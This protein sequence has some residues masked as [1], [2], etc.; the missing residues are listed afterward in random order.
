[1]PKKMFAHF[2]QNAPKSTFPGPIDIKICSKNSVRTGQIQTNQGVQDIP[3]C[4]K[5]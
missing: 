1:M 4:T 2:E 5:D 3:C